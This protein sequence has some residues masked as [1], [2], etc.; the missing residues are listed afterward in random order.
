MFFCDRI[1]GKVGQKPYQSLDRKH[2]FSAYE[3]AKNV[4]QKDWNAVLHGKDIF[5]SLEYLSILEAINGGTFRGVY[6]I[7]YENKVPLGIVYFQIIDFPA[8][9][10]GEL[11]EDQIKSLN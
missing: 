9:T 5:L 2:T 7:V 11:L 6:V 10:F 1:R 3:F 4:P 8:K